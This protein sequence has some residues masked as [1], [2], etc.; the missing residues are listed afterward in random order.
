M[1]IYFDPIARHTMHSI[2]LKN[3]EVDTLEKYYLSCHSH[4][5]IGS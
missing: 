3:G 5:F 4:Y 1:P 2:L